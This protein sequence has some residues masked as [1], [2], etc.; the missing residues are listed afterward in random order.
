MPA[1]AKLICTKGANGKS[2]CR[3]CNIEGWKDTRPGV[4]THYTPLHRTD[5][6][7]YDPLNLPLRSH[8]QTMER[9]AQIAEAPTTTRHD[10]LQRNFGINGISSL[11]TLPGI[12]VTGSFPHDLMHLDLDNVQQEAYRALGRRLQ[13]FGLWDRVIP[14]SALGV[15]R[16]WHGMRRVRQLDLDKFW[17]VCT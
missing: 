5:R 3:A 13:R 10:L 16:N 2:P 14:T 9:A 6:M 11:M 17:P 7:A 1:V 4:T 8:R 15:G 12:S